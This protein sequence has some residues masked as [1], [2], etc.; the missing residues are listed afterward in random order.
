MNGRETSASSSVGGGA[1]SSNNASK[2]TT[3]VHEGDSASNYGAGNA[4]SA[5]S[6]SSGMENTANVNSGLDDGLENYVVM[7]REHAKQSPFDLNKRL[8]KRKLSQKKSHAPLNLFAR[9][10]NCSIHVKQANKITTQFTY[11]SVS[12]CTTK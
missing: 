12:S 3:L 8:L 9:W 11:T 7:S 4:S 10:S 6:S 1:S 2:T 5:A